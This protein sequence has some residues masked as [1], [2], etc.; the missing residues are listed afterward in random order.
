MRPSASRASDGDRVVRGRLPG[1]RALGCAGSSTNI[2]A[3]V[4]IGKPS[5]GITGEDGIQAPEGVAETRLPSRSTA[6]S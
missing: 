5:D 3:R 1:S 4:P 2:W 6:S